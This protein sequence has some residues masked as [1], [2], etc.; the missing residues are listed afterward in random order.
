MNH[1]KAEFTNDVNKCGGNCVVFDIGAD[2]GQYTL[3]AAKLGKQVVSIE[4]YEQN[5]LRIHKASLRENLNGKIILIKNVIFNKRNK[6]AN[7]IKKNV[8][9]H[10]TNTREARYEIKISN[11]SIYSP[12]AISGSNFVKTILIDDFYNQIPKRSDGAMFKNAIMRLNL[13]GL[14]R[15]WI[16]NA[17]KLFDTYDVRS[18]Y[19]S[20]FSY[21]N[22]AGFVK[23]D[24]QVI[25]N[26]IDFLLK[27]K[28][29]PLDI[30]THG[31]LSLQ[32][33]KDWPEF[34][35]WKKKGF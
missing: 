24:Q 14:E 28:F 15:F 31:Q 19:M 1:F 30:P 13:N 18:I 7:L 27:R 6:I 8:S 11:D 26:M 22:E 12:S 16:V 3:F 32:G 21:T 20:W 10:L 2:L 17:T 25:Q 35:V 33:W 34:I 5:L 4:P 9:I 29:L 23:N